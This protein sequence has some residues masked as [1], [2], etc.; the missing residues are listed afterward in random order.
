M[1][2]R[3]ARR[4]LRN[5]CSLRPLRSRRFLLLVVVG[6]GAAEAGGRRDHRRDVRPRSRSGRRA[7]SDRV[8]HEAG[9]RRRLR[10]HDLSPR[11]EVRDGAGRR[12]AD[13]GSGEARALRH[14]RTERGE[15]RSAR[16]EDD[17]RIGRRRARCPAS[18]TAPA[19]SSSSSSPISRRSTTSTP[20]SRTSPTASRCCRRFPRRRSTTKGV[21]TERVEI[22]HVT[23]RD[24]PPEPFVTETRRGTRRLSRRPRHERRSDHDR[25]LRRQGAEHRSAV[26]AA[27]RGRRLQRHGV[28]PRRAGLRHPDRRAVEPRRAADREAAGAG[29]QPAAGVQ[30]HQAREGHRLDGARRRARQRD[31]VVL[32]LHGDVGAARRRLHGVRPSRRRDGGGRGDRS[33]AANRRG[34]E[35]A[36]RSAGQ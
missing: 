30:R 15:G 16:A 2:P 29:P 21:A 11:G 10:R 26:H 17:A 36:N 35:H 18:R 9:G 14:R 12:S 7:E 34:A 13:E 3:S 8:F 27:R 22:R 28:S 4:S 31:D 5:V 1:K 32:H 6:A 24:T 33:R 19:R 20:C 23:I 25:V